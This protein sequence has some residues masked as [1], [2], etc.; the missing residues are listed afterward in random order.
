MKNEKAELR[1]TKW[2][3]NE[4]EQWSLESFTLAEN[5]RI[6][7]AVNGKVNSIKIFPIGNKDI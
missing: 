3:L 5:F 1:A 7:V 4:K 6:A 2:A